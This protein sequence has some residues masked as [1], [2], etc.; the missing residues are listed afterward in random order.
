MVAIPGVPGGVADAGAA[1]DGQVAPRCGA[2]ARCVSLDITLGPFSCCSALCCRD[3]M[4]RVI[5]NP[6]RTR[7]SRGFLVFCVLCFVFCVFFLFGRGGCLRYDAVNNFTSLGAGLRH[8]YQNVP[9]SGAG[10]SPERE[11]SGLAAPLPPLPALPAPPA[12]PGSQEVRPGTLVY[13]NIPRHTYGNVLPDTPVVPVTAPRPAYSTVNK[14]TKG[15]KHDYCEL[16]K[17]PFGFISPSVRAPSPS[18][19]TPPSPP[20]FWLPAPLSVAVCR[21]IGSQKVGSGYFLV[22]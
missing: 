17:P 10:T 15:S 4:Y 9:N 20:F 18:P 8:G 1:G 12:R 2:E 13:E 16:P 21:R 3:G 5:C 11:G 7:A 22:H 14:G 19:R 6:T